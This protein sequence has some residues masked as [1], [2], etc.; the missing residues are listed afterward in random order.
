[1]AVQNGDIYGRGQSAIRPD[2]MTGEVWDYILMDGLQPQ[3]DIDPAILKVSVAWHDT[4]R[5]RGSWPFLVLAFHESQLH[6]HTM[7]EGDMACH[8]TATWTGG[9]LVL[10]SLYVTFDTASDDGLRFPV[11][12]RGCAYLG[13]G[14]Y[15][16]DPL[17]VE[18]SGA[19]LDT[20][21]A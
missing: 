11:S 16:P 3:G 7:L 20:A 13:S 14:V 8:G 4:Q 9:V 15:N 21:L 17:S 5:M 19:V 10:K 18:V 1:M 12:F 6:L 2:Q